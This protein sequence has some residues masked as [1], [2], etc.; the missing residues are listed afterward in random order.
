MYIKWEYATISDIP[1]RG[2]LLIFNWMVGRCSLR[3]WS[4][5]Q[6]SN[7]IS[8]DTQTHSVTNTRDYR[9]D[10]S[11][12]WGPSTGLNTNSLK[13]FHYISKQT[14]GQSVTITHVDH[15][16]IVISGDH[17]S[18]WLPSAN[19]RRLHYGTFLIAFGNLPDYRQ[20]IIVDCIMEL[21]V[22][23]FWD[24]RP[25]RCEGIGRFHTDVLSIPL[26]RRESL[27]FWFSCFS[28]ARFPFSVL[29]ILTPITIRIWA[30]C[31]CIHHGKPFMNQPL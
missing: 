30:L 4:D 25:H 8:K 1:G 13:F 5:T 24:L 23:C 12:T 22:H 14:Q 21:S 19:H 26:M 18:A 31:F 11:D 7:Y 6:F 20:Q 15:E 17:K 29:F 10:N 28:W 27:D 9:R 16:T 2:G 3:Y